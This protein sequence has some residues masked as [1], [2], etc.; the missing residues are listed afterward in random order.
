LLSGRDLLVKSDS[1]VFA[2]NNDEGRAF[3][4]SIFQQPAK[5][6]PDK[7]QKILKVKFHT[8][9]TPRANRALKQL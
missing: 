1:A 2:R 5:I 9:S 3:L 6:I 4:K 8:M 7:E